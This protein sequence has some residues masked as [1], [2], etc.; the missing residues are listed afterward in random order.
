M[1]MADRLEK[2]KVD[3]LLKLRE[4]QQNYSKELIEDIVNKPIYEL[5]DNF[6]E[7]IRVPFL[8]EISC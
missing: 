5:R 2:A 8:E 1:A 7:E 6:W 3:E 4:Q